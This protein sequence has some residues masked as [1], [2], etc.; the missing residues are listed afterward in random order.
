M[1]P[2]QGCSGGGVGGGGVHVVIVHFRRS[3]PTGARLPIVCVLSE[4]KKALARIP[5]AADFSL[6]RAAVYISVFVGSLN[7]P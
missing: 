3:L 7:A 1:I 5:E 4:K 2:K 6:H